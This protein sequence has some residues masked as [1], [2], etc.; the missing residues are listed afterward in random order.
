MASASCYCSSDPSFDR[1]A[2]SQ[3]PQKERVPQLGAQ[4]AHNVESENNSAP[5]ESALR[6]PRIGDFIGAEISRAKTREQQEYVEMQRIIF[7]HS[8]VGRL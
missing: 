7:F 1:V 8:Q 4:G 3:E 5:H 6:V 2:D